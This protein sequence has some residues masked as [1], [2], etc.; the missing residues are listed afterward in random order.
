MFVNSQIIEISRFHT[1]FWISSSSGKFFHP[2]ISS[3]SCYD[4]HIKIGFCKLSIYYK[5]NRGNLQIQVQAKMFQGFKLKY[6]ITEVL[7]N[8]WVL[9][10]KHSLK[11]IKPFNVV[12]NRYLVAQLVY[13]LFTFCLPMDAWPSPIVRSWRYTVYENKIRASFLTIENRL[14]FLLMWINE[15]HFLSKQINNLLLM[16]SNSRVS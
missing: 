9:V 13:L 16:N 4:L 15:I 8:F 14:I 11:K 5:Q 7:D 10:I 1:L 3:I 6:R 2:L 12:S